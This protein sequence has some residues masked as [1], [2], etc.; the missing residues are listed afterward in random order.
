M[1]LFSGYMG[2]FTLLSA[3]SGF[4]VILMSTPTP[5]ISIS[6]DYVDGAGAASGSCFR[7]ASTSCPALSRCSIVGTVAVDEY[8]RPV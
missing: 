3:Y 8:P 7:M 6:G 1:L 4:S 5:P 2:L